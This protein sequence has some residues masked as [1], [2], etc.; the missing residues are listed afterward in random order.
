MRC[1]KCKTL[2]LHSASGA[3]ETPRLVRCPRCPATWLA[4]TADGDAPPASPPPLIRRGALIIEGAIVPSGV[5][6]QPVRRAVSDP[7]ARHARLRR[8][9]IAAGAAAL[10]LAL[11]AGVLLA[12]GVSAL[13]GIAFLEGGR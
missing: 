6:G 5:A 13:P 11:F 3:G 7:M 4:R 1:P 2:T 9:G 12:P 10:V 8:Y